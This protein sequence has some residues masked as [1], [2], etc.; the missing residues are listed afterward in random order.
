LWLSYWPKQGTFDVPLVE[1]LSALPLEQAIDIGGCLHGLTIGALAWGAYSEARRWGAEAISLLDAVGERYFLNLEHVWSAL[2]KRGSGN[3]RRPDAT[4]HSPAR[5]AGAKDLTQHYLGTRD[6]RPVTR[7]QRGAGARGHA[8]QQFL[9]VRG[10]A[11][12]AAVL[13]ADVAAAAQ[14]RAGA[15]LWATAE[16]LLAELEARW[17]SGRALDWEELLAW[18]MAATSTAGSSPAVS[19]IQRPIP[20]FGREAELATLGAL[21][22][23]PERHLVTLTRVGGKE[24]ARYATQQDTDGS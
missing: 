2:A 3:Q 21:L 14:T 23:N 15:R 20:L 24:Q 9:V 1:Q 7:R 6:D 16:E 10:L 8:S 12:I 19:T 13:P 5:L 17:A 22:R 4:C 11:T 18:S